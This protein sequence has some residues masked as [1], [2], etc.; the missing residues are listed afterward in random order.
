MPQIHAL[1]YHF[2][3]W[4]NVSAEMIM[5][6]NQNF[7]MFGFPVDVLWMDIEWADQD[8]DPSGYEYFIFNPQNFTTHQIA[9]M[10]SEIAAS[11]RRITVIVDPHIKAVE[12]YF[13]WENG[14]ILE[15]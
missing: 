6:R 10:N 11:N 2:C 8:S 1:G 14:M 12:D 7:T 4:A 15:D 3:K 13:V 9:K 5:Q